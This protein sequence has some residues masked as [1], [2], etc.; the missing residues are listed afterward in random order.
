[1]TAAIEIKDLKKRYGKNRAVDGLSLTIP[2]GS[3]F[4]L[5]G[6]NGAGKTTT[7]GILGGAIQADSGEVNILGMGAFDPLKLKGRITFL[8]QDIK[9][10]GHALVREFL[11]YLAVLQGLKK[12]QAEKSVDAMLEWVDLKDRANHQIRTLSHG[13]LRRMNI[14]QAFLGTPDIVL[15]D[16]P[17]S[18]LDP[19]QLIHIRYLL[20]SLKGKQTVVISS[21]ILSEIEAVCDHVAFIEGGK[22]RRQGTL[23]GIIRRNSRITY[24]LNG[25]GFPADV[26]SPHIPQCRVSVNGETA[27]VQF[28]DSVYKAQDVN[29]IV[30]KLLLENDCEIL[31]VNLGSRLEQEYLQEM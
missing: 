30:L 9:M 29:K 7:L 11:L 31:E 24:R 6:P 12:A 5:V 22:T 16:E 1:M 13:M 20:K 18:G 4:G 23:S 28:P 14:A 3:V 25:P 19:K 17:V 15:M 2:K 8:P 26:I 10:S 21:H 27:V